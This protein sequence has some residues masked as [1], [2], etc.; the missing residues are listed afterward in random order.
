MKNQKKQKTSQKKK[1]RERERERERGRA[2]YTNKNVVV[3]PLFDAKNKA[4][5][6]IIMT[7]LLLVDGGRE[8]STRRRRRTRRRRA[9]ANDAK[10]IFF[11]FLFSLILLFFS[12][13]ENDHAKRSG[14]V[15]GVFVGA[16]RAGGRPSAGGLARRPATTTTAAARR[17][18]QQKQQREI[19]EKKR[20]I[21]KKEDERRAALLPPPPPPPKE[22]EEEEKASEGMVKEDDTEQMHSSFKPPNERGGE[23]EKKESIPEETTEEEEEAPTTPM[24]AKVPSEEVEALPRSS[25]PEE[26]EED[27]TTETSP[28]EEDVKKRGEGEEEKEQEQEVVEVQES[29]A[30]SIGDLGTDSSSETDFDAVSKNEER[31]GGTVVSESE[32]APITTSPEKE[33]AI[34]DAIVPPEEQ[35]VK[36]EE[37]EE[38]VDGEI[39]VGAEEEQP[40][41]EPVAAPELGEAKEEKILKDEEKSDE[42]A[43]EQL[44]KYEALIKEEEEEELEKMEKTKED[45]VQA[46]EQTEEGSVVAE[47]K[48]PEEIEEL[49]QPLDEEKKE[50]EDAP[51]HKTEKEVIFGGKSDTHDPLFV[52]DN[53]EEKAQVEENAPMQEADALSMDFTSDDAAPATDGAEEKEKKASEEVVVA[54]EETPVVAPSDELESSKEEEEKKVEQEDAPIKKEEE[55]EQ[56]KDW[57]K[58]HGVYQALLESEKSEEAVA[59]AIVSADKSSD[60]DANITTSSTTKATKVLGGIPKSLGV[61]SASPLTNPSLSFAAFRFSKRLGYAFARPGKC[62]CAGSCECAGACGSSMDSLEKQSTALKDAGVDA[63]ISV[64]SDASLVYN[65]DLNLERWIGEIADPAKYGLERLYAAVEYYISTDVENEDATFYSIMNKSPYPELAKC[66]VF[67][68]MFSQLREDRKNGKTVKVN[69]DAKDEAKLAVLTACDGFVNNPQATKFGGG[70]SA[71][72]I[73][74]RFDAIIPADSGLDGLIS[75]T[76]MSGFAI[77]DLAYGANEEDSKIS[78]MRKE[79][80]IS[81]DLANE[82]EAVL[83]RLRESNKVDEE[84]YKQSTAWLDGVKEAHRKA[85][86]AHKAI[87][88][89]WMEESDQYCESSSAGSKTCT[90][91]DSSSTTTTTTDQFAELLGS[92]PE[93]CK[94]SDPKTR[95]CVD[96]WWDCEG[97]GSEGSAFA[98]Q[99]SKTSATTTTTTTMTTPSDA[100]GDSGGST[101][102]GKGRVSAVEALSNFKYKVM[103]DREHPLNKAAQ[104][105]AHHSKKFARGTMNAVNVGAGHAVANFKKIP[106]GVHAGVAIVFIFSLFGYYTYSQYK[107][108]QPV[109]SLELNTSS[110]KVLKAFEN[111]EK[112]L[113]GISNVPAG[114]LMRDDAFW[115]GGLSQSEMERGTAGRGSSRLTGGKRRNRNTKSRG[116]MTEEELNFYDDVSD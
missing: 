82:A 44:S 104:F 72:E 113:R 28:V 89:V 23:E 114:E 63:G 75:L 16:S 115:G 5:P 7:T 95:S 27:A 59:D 60:G 34:D 111:K 2:Y 21:Q 50:E 87:V 33:Q 35:V 103:Y 38:Q 81:V 19:E 64:I 101:S 8:E 36:T 51:S 109:S 78:K 55:P 40:S 25:S 65:E 74:Q 56:E 67:D 83:K 58:S 107:S 1:Q 13:G 57:D 22:E 3:V 108:L 73:A 20:R 77:S 88:E 70:T 53:E 24:D 84:L 80:G 45:G 106:T 105:G 43:N 76:F 62:I 99:F 14:D 12:L 52:K 6:R 79:M 66:D 69:V 68:A 71:K 31:G 39:A 96:D 32:T 100:T 46:Q 94:A 26:A 47:E 49:P 9:S 41:V 48:T 86:N 61:V 37:E 92:F 4:I 11:F 112:A 90:R 85:F 102:G 97:P 15:V 30:L 29:D 54:S 42:K 91:D 18:Q 10:N 110:V 93:S 116:P 17:R 98:G